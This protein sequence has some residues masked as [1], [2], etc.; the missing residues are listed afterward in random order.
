MKVL[1]FTKYTRK[2]A[3][4]RLRS[5]QYFP[6][7]EKQGIE[8]TVSPFF[9][10][11]Y[12][13]NLYAKKSTIKQVIKA[14]THRFFSL[15]NVGRYDRIVIEKELF[16]YFPACFEFMFSL[17]HIKYIVDYD[18]AIFHNYDLNPNP[19]IRFLL[20]KK[21][22]QVMKYSQVVIAGNEYLANRAIQAEAKKVQILPTVIDLNRYTI[23]EQEYHSQVIV[24]WIGS[25]STFKYLQTIRNVLKQL[26]EKYNVLV[27]I[28]GAKDS[29][30]LGENEVHI[31]WSEDSEVDSILKFDIGIMSLSDTPWEKGK[32]A[33]KLIQYMGCGIPVV[34]SAVGMNNQVVKDGDSGFLPATEKEWFNCLEKYVINTNLRKEHG[35]L[36]RKI[37]CARYCL[38]VMVPEMGQIYRSFQ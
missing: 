11:E 38:D 14:Y 31:D 25:Q 8:I 2:G 28:V 3:S 5:Y 37:V 7:L 15:W 16:P 12:L 23:K 13:D 21:I 27:Y 26:I 17:L 33:Y 32:C 1:Y 6:Y 18:D 9:S 35:L 34:A 20:K 29:L 10:D 24:G 19:V 4:S 22:D 30:G 36:G